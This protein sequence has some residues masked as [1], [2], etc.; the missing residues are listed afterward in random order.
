VVAAVSCSAHNVMI[1][2]R[3]RTIIGLIILLIMRIHSTATATGSFTA[4]LSRPLVS[5]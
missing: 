4:H 1:D 3:A 5:D 2:R